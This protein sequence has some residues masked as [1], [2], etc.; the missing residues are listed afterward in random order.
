MR[1]YLIIG[2]AGSGKTTTGRE[3]QRRGYRTVDL[4]TVAKL[5]EWID[6]R[7]SKRILRVPKRPLSETWRHTHRRTWDPKIM[8]RLLAGNSD[9]IVY[10]CGGAE[11]DRN[12]F[13]DFRK[14]FGLHTDNQTL[15]RRLEQRNDRRWGPGSKELE[16]LLIWND[17]FTKFCNENGVA[18][19]DST[20][21]PEAVADLIL[22]QSDI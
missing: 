6:L 15:T 16:Q 19:V 4:D 22:A 7:N 10:F 13:D 11:N 8:H 2:P 1:A 20:R 3:L 9:E 21:S 12:F 14:C 5:V 17:R 18:I